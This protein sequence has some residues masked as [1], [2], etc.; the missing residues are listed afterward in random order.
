MRFAFRRLADG[1]MIAGRKRKSTPW[2]VQP[3]RR[4]DLTAGQLLSLQ[5]NQQPPEDVV[6][7]GAC[8]LFGY[9]GSQNSHC[10]P[11]ASF[12]SGSLRRV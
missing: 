8:S 12:G 3:N 9:M 2:E 1:E 5:I 6:Q 7:F 11:K 10:F 4:V